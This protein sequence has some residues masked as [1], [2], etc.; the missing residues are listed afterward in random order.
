MPHFMF[1]SRETNTRLV[2][3]LPLIVP[4]NCSFRVGN[5]TRPWEY[6]KAFVFDDSIEHEARNDSDDLRAVL[7]FDVWNPNLP[8]VERELVA[9]LVNGVRDYYQADD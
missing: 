7:I 9:A 2:V 4:P 8:P 6:G 3:H 5:E 1:R